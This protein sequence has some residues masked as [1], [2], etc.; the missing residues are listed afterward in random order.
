MNQAQ[1]QDIETFKGIALFTPGGDLIY[2]IDP[3]KQGR[4]H[5]H[6]CAGLQEILNLPEPPHFLVPCYTATIDRWLD[7]QTQQIQTYAEA[8]PLV[9]RYQPLLNAIFQT[10]VVWQAAPVTEGLCDPILLATYRASFPQLWE[11]HELVVRFE[12]SLTSSNLTEPVLP[13]PSTKPN[14]QPLG[15][16][17]HLFI[18]GHNPAT[19]RILQSLRQVLE[20]FNYPYTLKVIDVLKHP[21][22]AEI[23]QVTATPTLVKV[24]PKPTRR[25]VGNLDNAEKLLEL[26]TFP[27]I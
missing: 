17:L 2:C 8:Y 12:R 22:Q 21:E 26:L 6:L 11:E 25:L 1:S 16:T 13:Q 4:W 5:L 19:E 9:L 3:K 24:S 10:D 20:Q 18:A 27:E 14:L 23:Y 15:Y 7:P